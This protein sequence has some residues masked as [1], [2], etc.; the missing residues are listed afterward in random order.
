MAEDFQKELGAP[1]P[2]APPTPYTGSQPDIFGTIGKLASAFLDP[3]N[4]PTAQTQTQAYAEETARRSLRADDA[5]DKLS[6]GWNAINTGNFA[7][8]EAT[9]GPA[10][11]EI[12]QK[13]KNVN[14]ISA[15]GEMSLATRDVRIGML[16]NALEAYYPDAG[17]EIGKWMKENG[18]D[19]ILARS[20][21]V[22]EQQRTAELA[23]N[24]KFGDMVAEYGQKKGIWDPR[25]THDENLAYSY[26]VYAGEQRMTQAIEARKNAEEIMNSAR[27]GSADAREAAKRAWDEE[28]KHLATQLGDSYSLEADNTIRQV[29]RLANASQG[30]DKVQP[31]MQD[32]LAF[33]KTQLLQ[34]RQ[35]TLIK[36][37]EFRLGDAAETKINADFDRY[38]ALVNELISGPTSE[39][40]RRLGQVQ[41]I[42]AEGK[43]SAGK[44]LEV[45]NT[46]KKG[47]GQEVLNGLLNQTLPGFG[48][49]ELE[50][51][52]REMIEFVTST[53]VDGEAIKQKFD[54][55]TAALRAPDVDFSSIK[56]EASRTRQVQGAVMG[57][58]ASGNALMDPKVK[59]L[60]EQDKQAWINSTSNIIALGIA[61]SGPTTTL[62]NFGSMTNSV[63]NGRWLAQMNMFKAKGGTEEEVDNLY[64]FNAHGAA[65][66][67]DTVV[68]Q[69]GAQM[70]YNTT[71]G[72][73]V[74][75]VAASLPPIGV[76]GTASGYMTPLAM[77]GST[78]K[79]EVPED[80]KRAVNITNGLL[81]HLVK[82]DE[83]VK[84]VPDE[85]RKDAEGKKLSIREIYGSADGLSKSL[86]NWSAANTAAKDASLTSVDQIR[87]ALGTLREKTNVFEF[88]DLTVERSMASEWASVNSTPVAQNPYT[89]Y[90]AVTTDDE[91]IARTKQWESGGK[92]TAQNPDSS[93]GGPFQFIDSTWLRHFNQ[94]PQAANMTDKQ[95]LALKS[96]PDIA[97]QIQ[98]MDLAYN[99]Q[100]LQKMLGRPADYDELYLAHFFGPGGSR[101][102]GAAQFIQQAM[103]NP[104]E[105]ASKVVP[106]DKRNANERIFKGDPT[107]IE[108]YNRL[109]KREG[110]PEYVKYMQDKYPDGRAFTPPFDLF[111]GEADAIFAQGQAELEAARAQEAEATNRYYNT[112]NNDGPVNLNP[113]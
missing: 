104:F 36:A 73:W 94:L 4:A 64:R 9:F 93:A 101:A 7:A 83:F 32:T 78:G 113:Q 46:L 61:D 89:G 88:K 13:I 81:N 34:G 58:S 3:K 49:V 41:L 70:T 12:L 97:L 38:D 105:K 90:K 95:K 75:K 8:A 67:Y 22:M 51:V 103:S 23:R 45:Y 42:E 29:Y 86:Q 57:I 100:Q 69:Y 108:V 47:L 99:K 72:L 10:G 55:Y 18:V 39:V 106:A 112:L 92:N 74:G 26:N 16:V 84:I 44:G 87:K 30:K 96:N 54:D 80:V 98:K 65:D 20:Y 25:K 59:T 15:S 35:N 63:Y 5:T 62:D 11:Q 31:E 28:G 68:A 66:L 48:K 43:L 50:T 76:M 53:Q 17:G 1:N 85:A 37:R 82:L 19:H 2:G 110:D 56:D 27:L 14:A 21:D 40:K 6:I 77:P 79:S 102:F 71:T 60:G 109:L 52:R 107:V 111:G 33:V 24:I 91:W